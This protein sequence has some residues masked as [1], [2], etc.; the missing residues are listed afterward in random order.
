MSTLLTSLSP[1]DIA[2]AARRLEGAPAS[3]IVAWAVERCGSRLV[4]ACSM[5]DAVLIDVATKVDPDIEIVFLDTGFHF[6]ET[7]ATLRRA[8]VKYQLRVSVVRPEA[9]AP[10]VWEDGIDRCC[11]ARKVKPL[12]RALA[13]RLGWL[14]GIR[15]ADGVDRADTPVV[16]IDRRG[17]LKVNPLATWTDHDVQDYIER[18]DVV[19]N[20]L[21]D[22]GYPSIGCWPCTEP[23]SGDDLR[24]GRWSGTSKTECGLHL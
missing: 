12:E 10:S 15:R 9:H 21:L 22:M 23:A 17:L 3:E 14:S 4:I 13:D 18:H 2:H 20:P 6:P 8:M 7:L 16:H 19:T 5:T 11:A 1:V 24:G